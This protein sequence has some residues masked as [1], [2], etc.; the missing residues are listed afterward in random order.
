MKLL[1][2]IS[3]ID[4]TREK[5]LNIFKQNIK[6]YYPNGKFKVEYTG[7]DGNK[8]IVEILI[9]TRISQSRYIEGTWY[10]NDKIYVSSKFGN[11]LDVL[12]TLAHELVH[13]GQRWNGALNY[14]RYIDSTVNNKRKA[15]NQI[16]VT[17]KNLPYYKHSE[18]QIEKE[19]TIIS[20]LTL[21]Q[22]NHF[23]FAAKLTWNYKNYF[24]KITKQQFLRNCYL[25]KISNEQLNQYRQHV[26]KVFDRKI[27]NEQIH[28]NYNIFNVNK[29][30][31]LLN[32]DISN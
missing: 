7:K 9:S 3:N 5:V 1:E 11:E 26:A 31:N 32:I 24:D 6:K 18:K 19:A 30:I 22:E 20:I 12:K 27:N 14:S 29:I 25:M 28:S 8:Y 4:G 2:G 13:L 21:I 15:K 10:Q 17:K 16:Y 23:E